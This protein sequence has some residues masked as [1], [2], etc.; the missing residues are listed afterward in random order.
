VKAAIDNVEDYLAKNF[1]GR[2]LPK[3]CAKSPFAS[4][5]RPELDLSP[6]LDDKLCNYYQSQIGV[7]RWMV[8]LGRVDII[9]EVSELASQL[10]LPREGHLDAVFRI[11]SYLKYKRNSLMVYNPMYPT[12]KKDNFPK[13]NWNNFYGRVK[14]IL[15]PAM[16][17]PLGL[18]VIIRVFVD[19]DYAGDNANRRSRTGFIIFLNEAPIAWYS[20]KQS[21]IENSVFGSEF[22]AMRTALET[23]QGIRYKIRMMG[24]PL[25]TPVYIYG[26]NMSVIHNTSKPESTLKKKANSVC[27]H[28]IR[29]AAAADECRTGHVSTHEN[30][31]DIATKPLPAGEKR[32]YLVSKLLYFFSD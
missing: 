5:Y 16:P 10:A 9:T 32:D 8:E 22:I 23:V 12:I 11:Y 14:E 4:N 7:L 25:N 19:A 13:R 21:R 29:E 31:A 26:D 27:F 30:P 28:Y 6:E 18:E 2:K 1:N 3:K 20:K 17:N 24:V 15:P